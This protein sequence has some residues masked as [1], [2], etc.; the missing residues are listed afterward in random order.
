[1]APGFGG[2]QRL[3]RHGMGRVAPKRLAPAARVSPNLSALL[4]LCAPRRPESLWK[5]REKGGEEI[6]SAEW[7]SPIIISPVSQKVHVA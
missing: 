5:G 6:I 4:E 3:C 7:I 1:M 2:L